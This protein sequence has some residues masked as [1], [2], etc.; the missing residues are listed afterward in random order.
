MD[1]KIIN[2]CLNFGEMEKS[3]S[4]ALKIAISVQQLRVHGNDDTHIPQD[5]FRFNSRMSGC[6]VSCER[7]FF[8]RNLPRVG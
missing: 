8:A 3:L 5:Y 2:T 1:S 4:F 6:C 7:L